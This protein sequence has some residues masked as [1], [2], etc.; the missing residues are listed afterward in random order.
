MFSLVFLFFFK[1]QKQGKEGNITYI[2]TG[3][4]TEGI[5]SGTLGIPRLGG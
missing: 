1:K 3:N 5:E 2:L 4:R